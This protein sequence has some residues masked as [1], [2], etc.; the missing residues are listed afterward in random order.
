MTS[1]NFVKGKGLMA[2]LDVYNTIDLNFCPQAD[3]DALAADT[4]VI[5]KQFKAPLV[6]MNGPRYWV[7]DNMRNSTM[8]DDTVV[9]VGGDENPNRYGT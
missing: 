9:L 1:T 4:S 7:I 3:F 8:M 5:K 6:I 2:N